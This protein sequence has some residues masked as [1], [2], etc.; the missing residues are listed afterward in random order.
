MC[1]GSCNANELVC[2]DAPQNIAGEFIEA[3][4]PGTIALSNTIVDDADPNVEVTD[5]DSTTT[6]TQQS[7]L[8]S[9][10]TQDDSEITRSNANLAAN[11][12]SLRSAVINAG[13][14]AD[15]ASGTMNVFMETPVDTP[16]ET[17]L[18]VGATTSDIKTGGVDKSVIGIIIAGM[19]LI[20]AGITIKKNWSSIRKRFSPSPRPA[21][22]VAINGSTPE[23]MPLQENDKSPV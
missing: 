3:K 4:L 23:E 18:K 17:D 6:E 7:T 9:E 13:G 2:S 19:I 16:E 22:G 20:V 5:S 1:I 10:A 15:T 8:T 21:N 12:F 11:D 14:T